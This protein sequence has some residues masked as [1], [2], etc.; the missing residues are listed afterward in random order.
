MRIHA[1]VSNIQID[2]TNEHNKIKPTAKM[3]LIYY[4][5]A[6]EMS[7]NNLRYVI[8]ILSLD[9]KRK[10]HQFM[11]PVKTLLMK[12]IAPKFAADFHHPNKGN[13]YTKHSFKTL[14]YYVAH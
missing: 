7:S 10:P 9:S 1:Q 14:I 8:H 12:M 6:S 2:V 4:V 5:V 3:R 13:D 11:Q